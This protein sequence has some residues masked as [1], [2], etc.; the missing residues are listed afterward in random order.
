MAYIVR[1]S[2]LPRIV[3]YVDTIEAADRLLQTLGDVIHFER[4]PD[5]DAADAAVF[6][7]GELQ[8]FT[9]ERELAS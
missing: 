3:S 1:E 4:D 6:V 5:H 8:I 2:R 9:I 7:E